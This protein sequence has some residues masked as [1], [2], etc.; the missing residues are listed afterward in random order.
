MYKIV[1]GRVT[2]HKHNKTEPVG[3]EASQKKVGK[4]LRVKEGYNPNSSSIGSV[5]FAIPLAVLAVPALFGMASAVIMQKGVKAEE[6]EE[7]RN[8]SEK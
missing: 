3:L 1:K 4:L 2:M 8:D 7:E 5:V 6:S